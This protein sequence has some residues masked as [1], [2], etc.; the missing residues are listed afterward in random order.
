MNVEYIQWLFTTNKFITYL[1]NLV[2][3]GLSLNLKLNLILEVVL[4]LKFYHKKLCVK[5]ISVW[6]SAFIQPNKY[7]ENFNRT[8]II[9]LIVINSCLKLVVSFYRLCFETFVVVAFLNIYFFEIQ[10]EFTLV[11]K[12]NRIFKLQLFWFKMF[13]NGKRK[14]NYS[15]ILKMLFS[16]NLSSL[17]NP[18]KLLL[19]VVIFN[20]FFALLRVLRTFFCYFFIKS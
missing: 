10:V 1:I 2:K 8:Y 20:N 11:I 5:L 3:I 4:S 7:N 13:W 14:V 9:K 19:L 12:L 6:D 16:K 18:T 17:L 15:K